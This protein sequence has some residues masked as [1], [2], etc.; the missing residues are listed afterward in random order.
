MIKIFIVECDLCGK[1][2]NAIQERY[3]KTEYEDLCL[4]C[5][6]E[7]RLVQSNRCRDTGG[8]TCYLARRSLLISRTGKPREPRREGL[9]DVR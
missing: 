1:E 3:I 5:Y 2:M 7:A 4:K 6:N 9:H 8:P